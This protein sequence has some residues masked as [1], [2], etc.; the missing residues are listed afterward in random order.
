MYFQGQRYTCNE[1]GADFSDNSDIKDH[2]YKHSGYIFPC[3]LCNKPFETPGLNKIHQITCKNVRPGSYKEFVCDICCYGC[4]T[5]LDLEEHKQNHS[6][7]R[8]FP[9]TLCSYDF[10]T[11]DALTVHMSRHTKTNS[12]SC[13]KCSK[14]FN[15]RTD[16]RDHLKRM[17]KRFQCSTCSKSFNMDSAYRVH[18]KRCILKL[19]Q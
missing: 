8:P 15:T 9:C 6:N 2:M 11:E 14:T 18:L 19:A 5:E 7:E 4:E 1:C 12:V 13:D 17:H 3:F 10:E 16:L